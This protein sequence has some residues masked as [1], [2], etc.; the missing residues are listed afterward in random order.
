MPNDHDH[1]QDLLNRWGPM[2][3]PPFKEELDTLLSQMLYKERAR[4]V[5]VLEEFISSIEHNTEES[6]AS[7][8]VEQL[9]TFFSYVIHRLTHL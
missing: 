3:D 7:V 1:V 4:L 8:T 2:D 6:G 9:K 5:K